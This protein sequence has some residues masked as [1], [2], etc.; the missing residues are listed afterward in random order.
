MLGITS[1]AGAPADP[2]RFGYGVGGTPPL[3]PGAGAPAGGDPAPADRRSSE[4]GVGRSPSVRQSAGV[5]ARETPARSAAPIALAS[6]MQ[7]PSNAAR[8]LIACT[9]A[10]RAEYAAAGTTLPPVV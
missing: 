1:Q 2:G 8:L 6:L 7:N 4:Y 9:A 5:S 10:G 3:R